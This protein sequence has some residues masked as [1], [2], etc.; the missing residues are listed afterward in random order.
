M[1]DSNG[2]VLYDRDAVSGKVPV[3]A[4]SSLTIDH[5]GNNNSQCTH[6]TQWYDDNTRVSW[7]AYDDGSQ[8][9]MHT[10]DQSLAKGSKNRHK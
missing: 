10:T 6:V 2:R 8:Q 3:G 5:T 4:N 9:N 7:D 1:S